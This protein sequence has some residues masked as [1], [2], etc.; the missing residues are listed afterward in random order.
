MTAKG[1]A[2]RDQWGTDKLCIYC[3]IEFDDSFDLAHHIVEQHKGTYAFDEIETI[4]GY[5]LK[6]ASS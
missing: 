2:Y 4:T 1:K 3:Q 6:E 5:T